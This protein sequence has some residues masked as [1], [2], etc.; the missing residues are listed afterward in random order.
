[1]I[2][3]RACKAVEQAVAE[4][5]RGATVLSVTP[6]VDTDGRITFNRI[7]IRLLNGEELKIISDKDT[8]T[9]EA[10]IVVIKNSAFGPIEMDAFEDYS[11]VDPELKWFPDFPEPWDKD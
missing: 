6:S 11:D 7:I 2:S 9:S 1:M 5:F 10:I 3:E 4:D 8:G